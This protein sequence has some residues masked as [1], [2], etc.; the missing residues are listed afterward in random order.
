M[1]RAEPLLR[2]RGT[3]Y[4]GQDITMLVCRS[5]EISGRGKAPGSQG[6]SAKSPRGRAT[7]AEPPESERS[8]GKS[9][10]APSV[11]RRRACVPCC[12]HPGKRASDPNQ[13]RCPAICWAEW[14][15]WVVMSV[16]GSPRCR[17]SWDCWRARREPAA[18]TARSRGP[19][20]CARSARASRGRR[21]AGRVATSPR[22]RRV[23]GPR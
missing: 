7:Y 10:P 2:P 12:A 8:T 5:V 13:S 3:V 4:P 22:R 23:S 18:V 6:R 11:A 17:D 14:S 16:A 20:R 15:S 9:I 21:L 19:T 1:R